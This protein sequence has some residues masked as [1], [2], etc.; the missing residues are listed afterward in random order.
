MTPFEIIVLTVVCLGFALAVGL[1]IYKKVKHKGG[2]CDCAD[3]SYCSGCPDCQAHKRNK[4]D[5]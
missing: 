4:R 1:F 3:K 5:K 2:C